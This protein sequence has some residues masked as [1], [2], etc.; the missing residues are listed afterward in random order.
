M[1]KGEASKQ[2]KRCITCSPISSAGSA[3]GE[4]NA[5]DSV[6][7]TSD[8]LIPQPT[9]FIRSPDQYV[10]LA[11]L[12]R[13]MRSILPPHA[14]IADDAKETIQECVSEFITLV[15]NEANARCHGELRKTIYAEDVVSAMGTLGFQN[16]KELLTCYLKRYRMDGINGRYAATMPLMISTRGHAQMNF[17]QSH[18]N[19]QL[20]PRPPNFMANAPSHY[21]L[22][23]P[24]IPNIYGSDAYGE[25]D[26]GKP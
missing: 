16:Y 4:A 18:Y 12:T 1:E 5:A 13:I 6:S 11:N 25:D 15:T 24:A 3:T 22:G 2:Q 26:Q 9:T 20:L 21:A 23:G 10:P 19:G 17:A 8:A 7:I 14:K